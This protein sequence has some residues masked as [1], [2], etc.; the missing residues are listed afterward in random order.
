MSRAKMAGMKNKSDSREVSGGP[1]PCQGVSIKGM[2]VCINAHGMAVD[3][4]KAI[5][6]HAALMEVC[7]GFS[8]CLAKTEYD[9][10]GIFWIEVYSAPHPST[11]II[12]PSFMVAIW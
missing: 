3:H 1:H 10:H 7:Q 6:G 12:L 9:F 8:E 5:R 2:A 11:T 4:Y